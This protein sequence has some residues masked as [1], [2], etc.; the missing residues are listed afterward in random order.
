MTN[1]TAGIVG[2]RADNEGA[3]SHIATTNSNNQPRTNGAGGR[4]NEM[5]VVQMG[6][7]KK[8]SSK[9]KNS[10]GPLTVTL[11]TNSQIGG[12]S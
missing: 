6:P 12:G 7:D 8:N 2:Q 5:E 4:S 1:P 11:Q 10:N 3:N 9:N